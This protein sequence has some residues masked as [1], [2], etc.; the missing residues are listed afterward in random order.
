MLV[1]LRG[2]AR[3]DLLTVGAVLSDQVSVETLIYVDFS[4]VHP[5]QLDTEERKRRFQFVNVEQRWT[6]DLLRGFRSITAMKCVQPNSRQ[7][8]FLWF[9]WAIK[10]KDAKESVL[11]GRTNTEISIQWQ[12][13]SRLFIYSLSVVGLCRY[14]CTDQVLDDLLYLGLSLLHL[15]CRPFQTDALLAVCELYVNLHTGTKATLLGNFLLCW[16]LNTTIHLSLRKV[17][18]LKCSPV[19]IYFALLVPFYKMQPPKSCC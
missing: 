15:L 4:V 13:S 19:T 10:H 16:V 5:H 8:L 11:K 14:V 2:R 17:S 9:L 7:Q 1:F 18:N 3:S 6:L 12:I